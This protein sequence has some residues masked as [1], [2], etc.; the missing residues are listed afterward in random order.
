MSTKTPE[1]I[2]SKLKNY[3]KRNITDKLLLLLILS[4][5][6]EKLRA[7]S[8]VAFQDIL[9]QGLRQ[10]HTPLTKAS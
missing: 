9:E 10:I 5:R 8:E 7:G 3:L 6:R 1:M 2:K 4:F